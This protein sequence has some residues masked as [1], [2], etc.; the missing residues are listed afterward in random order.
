MVVTMKSTIF[1]CVTQ[2]RLLELHRYFGGTYYLKLNGRTVSET[3]NYREVL[4]V[5]DRFTAL[6][7]TV[8]GAPTA[9][10]RIRIL[11]LNRYAYWPI[12]LGIK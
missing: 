9:E 10:K 7:F 1:F 11:P 5:V 4:A 8:T 12:T 6:R 3:G 2:C